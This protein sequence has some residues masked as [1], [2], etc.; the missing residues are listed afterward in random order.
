MHIDGSKRT[1]HCAFLTADA[2]VGINLSYACR[3]I[4]MA[5]AGGAYCSAG[6]IGACITPDDK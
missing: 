2:F 3:N 4:H 6:R 1:G 5:G